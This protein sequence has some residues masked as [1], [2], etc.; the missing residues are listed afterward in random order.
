MPSYEYSIP[1]RADESGNWKPLIQSFRQVNTGIIANGAG[2]ALDCSS[3]PRESISM[4]VKRTAGLT[5][6]CAIN[7]QISLNGTDW[8]TL[9]G[10]AGAGFGGPVAVQSFLYNNPAYACAH[11]GPFKY[12]RY[13][14]VTV[15]AGNTLSIELLAG[16]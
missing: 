9:T 2:P 15:G 13:N 1:C 10:T 14:V 4:V 12:V 16:Q 7:I 11:T 6:S 5:D 3:C 8:V